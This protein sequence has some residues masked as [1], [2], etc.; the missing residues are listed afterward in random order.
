MMG[1]ATGRTC[2]SEVLEL[3]DRR[4]LRRRE[5]HARVVANASQT[6][7]VLRVVFAIGLVAYALLHPQWFWLLFVAIGVG[8]AGLRE[9][10]LA[11]RRDRAGTGV[12][13]VSLKAPAPTAP[14]HEVDALCDQ[15]LGELKT[16]PDAVR[17]FVQQPE[18]TIEALR[19]TAKKV[20][21]R[22][23]ALAAEHAPTKL[24]EL[25]TQREALIVRRDSVTDAIA[26]QKLD[27]A[28]R[29]L[30]GQRA[31]LLQLVATAERLDGEYTSLLML[32]QEL[33][34]RVAVARSSSSTPQ[35]LEANV[36]RLN[37]EL[38]A[39]SESLQRHE[40]LR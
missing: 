30:D 17:A 40:P 12:A 10:A 32:L 7:G 9:L 28:L 2:S 38:E 37:A 21:Q 6:A 20:D 1:T 39:I 22:R 3:S 14:R 35:G 29:S 33:R 16:S 25:A 15:L 5:R 8:S 23:A 27:D 18:E 36:Q 13:P 26:R 4:A 34:T 11:E 24:A 19:S 31:A